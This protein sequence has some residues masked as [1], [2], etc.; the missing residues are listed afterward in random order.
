MKYK[1]GD[2]V[3]VRSW[4]DMKKEFGLMK[5]GSINTYYRFTPFMRKFCGKVV[6]ISEVNSNSYHV[7]EDVNY[8]LF[9]D[10]MLEN[11]IEVVVIYRNGNKVVACDKQTKKEG[12]AICSPEDEFNFYIGAELALARLA[13]TKEPAKERGSKYYSGDIVC[14]STAASNLTVGKIYKVREGKFRDNNGGV[15]GSIY[16]YTS[17]EDLKAN[18]LSK[19]VEFV[20]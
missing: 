7:K 11:P 20:R 13:G 8:C 1:V 19:F 9:I 17:F 6:T 2:K 15:H 18:H 12:I 14:V 4:E 3:K 10:D 16:P 5:D